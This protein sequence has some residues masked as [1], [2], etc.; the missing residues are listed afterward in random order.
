MFIYLYC[1]YL[2]AS[3]QGTIKQWC[4]L[5]VSDRRKVESMVYHIAFSD[6]AGGWRKI[7]HFGR[8]N[9]YLYIYCISS[10]IYIYYTP[11]H[12]TSC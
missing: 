11:E 12:L 6:V 3:T 9:L 8:K 4:P 7:S 5:L 2:M 1:I 10:Y